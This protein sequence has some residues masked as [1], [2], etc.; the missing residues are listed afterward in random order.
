[1]AWCKASSTLYYPSVAYSVTGNV[2]YGVCRQSSLASCAA[3]ANWETQSVVASGNVNNK[4][5][6]DPTVA[7]DVPKIADFGFSTLN[8]SYERYTKEG[9]IFI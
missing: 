3:T 7:D 6:L 9:V 4:I 5:Y 1:M 2:K 8:K